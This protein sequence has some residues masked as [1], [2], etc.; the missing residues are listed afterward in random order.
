[1]QPKNEPTIGTLMKES[2]SRDKNKLV[3]SCQFMHREFLVRISKV[4]IHLQVWLVIYF[5]KT[6]NE[7]F[8]YFSWARHSYRLRGIVIFEDL[9]VYLSCLKVD[10]LFL[11]TE[12]QHWAVNLRCSQDPLQHFF[13][14][15]TVWYVNN[16]PTTHFPITYLDSQH[17][18]VLYYHCHIAQCICMIHR[19][20]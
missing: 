14:L 13:V 8:V 5:F 15:L 12:V 2:R 16:L 19:L 17:V 11:M 20:I 6:D 4:I 10:I 3:K 7:Y 1:M 9:F 18:F